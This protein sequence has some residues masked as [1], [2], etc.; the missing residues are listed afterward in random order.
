MN[1]IKVLTVICLVITVVSCSKKTVPAQPSVQVQPAPAKPGTVKAINIDTVAA[2][3]TD[4]VATAT[5]VAKPVV[6]KP[7]EATPKVITVNDQAAKKTIDGRYY[8]DLLGHRYWRNN[9]D[10]KYYLYNKSM[11]ND[12][13]FKKP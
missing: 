6:K 11:H 8:Y 2:V 12:P 9:K 3:K 1:K 5:T 4:T 7:V 13:A 10:G